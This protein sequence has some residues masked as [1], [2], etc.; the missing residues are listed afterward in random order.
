MSDFFKKILA[1]WCELRL[2]RVGRPITIQD[3]AGYRFWQYPGDC[4]RNNIMR[5][6]VADSVHVARYIHNTVKSGSV[7]IDI[8]ANIGAISL[9][10]W[11][12]AV[13]GGCVISV[14]ADPRN[15]P[16]LKANLRLNGYPDG[17]VV[18]AAVADQNV[19]MKLRCY[20]PDHNGWQ[21][22]G[23]PRFS[24]G[25]DSFTIDVQAVTFRD[26]VASRKFE[27][28]DFVKMD[29]EGAELL[30]LDGM[31]ACLK[32]EQIGCVIFEVNPLTLEGFGRTVSDLMR[33][34]TGFNYRL[35]LLDQNGSPTPLVGEWPETLV[36]DCIAVPME[37]HASVL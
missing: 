19:E 21:T 23:N 22:L 37:G 8:G 32:K 28:V 13:P 17:H 33:F 9:A 34:W 26:L 10:L 18:N 12:R 15:I 16:R 25:V 5:E 6:A 30:V 35:F 7:C 2:K 3:W 11:S 4:V 27:R 24:R 29:V 14:E 36:G 1:Y 31:A 20:P